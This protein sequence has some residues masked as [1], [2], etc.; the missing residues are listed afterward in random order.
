MRE[1]IKP[2]A[3]R[4]PYPCPDDKMK[5][6]VDKGKKKIKEYIEATKKKTSRKRKQHY[7]GKSRELGRS[8][9]KKRKG[10][11]DKNSSSSSSLS[12]SSSSST[13]SQSS[14]SSTSAYSGTSGSSDFYSST[15]SSPSDSE[16]RLA[17]GSK[18]DG[19]L[20]EQCFINFLQKCY[21]FLRFYVSI[22][23]LREN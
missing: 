21:C 7:A 11:C 5:K 19:W 13:T 12:N 23:L 4:L 16:W 15:G 22:Y 20:M 1:I 8:S 14:S 10:S 17:G 18:W 9:R 6:L 3:K 2:Y